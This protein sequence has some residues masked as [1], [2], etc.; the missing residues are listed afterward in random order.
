MGPLLSSSSASRKL[1]ILPS[2]VPGQV[3]M[4]GVAVALLGEFR[5]HPFESPF[6][7]SLG[8]PTLAF[9]LLYFTH[10]PHLGSSIVT[11]G[12]IFA[13]RS[14]LTLAFDWGTR[15]VIIPE[16]AVFTT[17][18]KLHGPAS[19]YYIALGL[20]FYLLR[21]RK[22]VHRP[23][24]LVATL[25]LAD[26]GGNVIEVFLRGR[27][28]LTPSVFSWIFTIGVLRASML[29]GLYHVLKRRE[30]ELYLQEQRKKYKELLMF[31][32]DLNTES[33]YL[34]KSSK[35]IEK[36]M[37][38]S[39][40]LYEELLE[41]LPEKAA[42][43]LDIAKDVHEIKKDYQRIITGLDRIMKRKDLEPEMRFSDIVA[44][45]ESSNEL[46]ARHLGK[47]IRFVTRLHQDFSTP[48]YRNWVSILNNLVT[49]AVEASGPRGRIEISARLAEDNIIVEVLDEGKGIPREDWEV[50][51]SPGYSTKADHKSGKIATGIGLTHVRSLAEEFGGRVQI[52]ESSSPGACFQIVAPSRTT[53]P[54]EPDLA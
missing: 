47:K 11:A 45:V 13:W 7:F 12:A 31:L 21:V 3:I 52:V 24:L 4:V 9:S 2:S 35:E 15:G 36:V 20:W 19:V 8:P 17:L 49:N 27:E 34:K 29:L 33:F 38:R 10:L 39:Y 23:V 26:A 41:A 44:L 53:K 54:A 16:G 43:A 42:L 32:I 18:L 51:F 48:H 1:A 22:H 37:K 14:Y 25:A 6:R 50:V 5:I 30:A 46:Y 40:G 28:L